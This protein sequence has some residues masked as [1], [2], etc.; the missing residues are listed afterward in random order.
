MILGVIS[1]GEKYSFKKKSTNQH[2][3]LKLPDATVNEVM[4][5]LTTTN[6]YQIS[7]DPIRDSTD[8]DDLMKLFDQSSGFTLPTS[9]LLEPD[10]IIVIS[11]ASLQ[12]KSTTYQT[13]IQNLT[14][15]PLLD[16]GTNI[17]VILETIF[18]SLPQKPQLSK[19]HTHKVISGS[20]ANLGPIG[21]CCLTFS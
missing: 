18:K 7:Q 11:E 10:H 3:C 6:N 4:E 14:T 15:V 5:S 17:S 2:E 1:I 12:G 20:G 19:V 16:T 8:E 21:Q 13:T 9:D